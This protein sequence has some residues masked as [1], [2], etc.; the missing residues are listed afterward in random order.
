MRNLEEKIPKIDSITIPDYDVENWIKDLMAAGFDQEEI[1]L[2]MTHNN[3][4]YARA[5]LRRFLDEE[6][7]L[8]EE[9]YKKHIGHGLAPEQKA[10]LEKFILQRLMQINLRDLEDGYRPNY[11][12]A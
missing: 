10:K 12:E 11:N 8:L 5:R 1:D 7:N 2:I 3:K 4:T 9:S 6:I